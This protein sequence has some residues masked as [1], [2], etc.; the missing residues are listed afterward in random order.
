MGFIM[1]TEQ[2]I[3]ALLILLFVTGLGF[4][5]TGAKGDARQSSWTEADQL[6]AQIAALYKQGQFVKALTLAQREVALRESASGPNDVA[7]A[8]VSRN[9]AEL[10]FAKGKYKDANVGYRRFLL[11]YE[12]TFG[13][14]SPKI[15]DPLYRYV[16]FLIAANQRPEALDTQKRVFRLENGF[17]VTNL[18]NSQNDAIFARPLQR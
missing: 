14:D 2:S 9:I 5:Q 7:G 6:E 3:G 1:K 8:D 4:A 13:A 18:D 12:K 11:I 15:V 10:F 17:G 16:S